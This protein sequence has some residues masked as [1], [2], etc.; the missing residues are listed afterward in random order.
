MNL[1]FATFELVQF[2]AYGSLTTHTSSCCGTR[3]T[4]WHQSCNK[5]TPN[6][7]DATI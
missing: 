6:S 1:H 7:E 3:T 4:F 5:W 2:L